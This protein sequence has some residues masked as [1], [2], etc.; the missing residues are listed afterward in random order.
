MTDLSPASAMDLAQIFLDQTGHAMETG[1]FDQ[2]AACFAFPQEIDT[3]DGRRLISTPQEL[4]EIF[5]S[6]RRHYQSLGATSVVRHVVQAEFEDPDTLIATHETRVLNHD[7]LVQTPFPV[8]SV[9]KRTE[10]GWKIT[11]SQY[12]IVD[13]PAHNAALSGHKPPQADTTE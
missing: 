1:N 8:F 12:A 5:D 3:F 11:M 10:D 2:L 9:A 6:V 7:Q 13:A 4:K